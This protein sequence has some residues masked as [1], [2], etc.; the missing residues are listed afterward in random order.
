MRVTI[1]PEDGFVSIDDEG[2][3]A[4]DLSFIPYEV[5]A[6]QWYDDEGEIEYQD[7]RGRATHNAA[8]TSLEQFPY[9]EQAYA[10]WQEAKNE[11]EQAAAQVQTPEPEQG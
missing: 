4:L 6:L 2:Y 9:W 3:N 7:K 1:I 8:I 10:A 5:H 11:A